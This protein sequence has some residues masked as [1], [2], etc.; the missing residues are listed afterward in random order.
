MVLYATDRSA[1]RNWRFA[2]PHSHR[3]FD[4]TRL[5]ALLVDA[6]FAAD[7]IRIEGVDAG[8]GVAGLLAVAQKE[9]R[10]VQGTL[11]VRRGRG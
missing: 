10:P 6:G 8:F 1:M 5:A 9:G 2:G 7:H 3:L 4:Q 11:L